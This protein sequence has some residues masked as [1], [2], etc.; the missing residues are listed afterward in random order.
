M[1]SVDYYD[2]AHE[3]ANGMAKVSALLWL[4]ADL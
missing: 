2:W 1:I 4:Y 3:T